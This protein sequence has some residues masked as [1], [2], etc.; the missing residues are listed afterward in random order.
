VSIKVILAEEAE[1]FAIHEAI[2]GTLQRH[3]DG[4]GAGKV[5]SYDVPSSM[6]RRSGTF[7]GKPV[8]QSLR[9]QPVPRIRSNIRAERGAG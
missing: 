4:A 5:N 7:D 1:S 6:K 2:A 3:I 8:Q 9:L